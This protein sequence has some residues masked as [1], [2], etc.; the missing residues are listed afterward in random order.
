M[1][2][3]KNK[4]TEFIS[5]QRRCISSGVLIFKGHAFSL[6][7]LVLPSLFQVDAF[8]HHLLFRLRSTTS[9]REAV[10]AFRHRR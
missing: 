9:S 2:L 10:S 7:S 5:T 8:I 1:T 3:F 6:S 4:G